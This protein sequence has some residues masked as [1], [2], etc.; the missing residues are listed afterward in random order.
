MVKKMSCIGCG[1]LTCER[2]NVKSDY[3]C[4]CDG[5]E[6][7][8]PVSSWCDICQTEYSQEELIID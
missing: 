3:C 7:D 4:D 2:L 1:H 8:K 6:E 5:L